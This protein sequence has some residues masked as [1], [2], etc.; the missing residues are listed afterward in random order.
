MNTLRLNEKKGIPVPNKN[1]STNF[2]AI[3][4]DGKRLFALK[5]SQSNKISTLFSYQDF[6]TG[7]SYKT[8]KYTNQMGHGNGMCYWEGK[9]YI[10]PLDK[11]IQVIDEKNGMK[12]TK[13]TTPININS[14]A[15]YRGNLFLAGLNLIRITGRAVELVKKLKLSWEDPSF[16]IGQDIGFH[17]G[18]L[19]I[20]RSSSEKN[21]NLIIRCPFD[22]KVGTLSP[23]RIYV[24][25]K[26]KDLYEFES[27]DFLS[28]TMVI[29]A[30]VVSDKDGIFTA[31]DA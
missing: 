25:E 14:I 24:S 15:H 18:R 13:L 29:A 1:G 23:D 20:I 16:P 5:T 17:K 3:A 12:R 8:R 2:G 4:M 6:R 30:N 9:L 19:Y 26:H 11:Y 7:C 31:K 10:A 22:G 21:Q 27:I 28:N